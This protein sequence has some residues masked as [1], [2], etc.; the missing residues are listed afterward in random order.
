MEIPKAKAF[1]DDSEKSVGI[2]MD[3]ICDFIFYSFNS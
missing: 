2:R 1:S 3:L